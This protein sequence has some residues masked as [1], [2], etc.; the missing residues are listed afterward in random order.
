MMKKPVFDPETREGAIVKPPVLTRCCKRS[1]RLLL[2][3]ARLRKGILRLA[4]AERAAEGL[5]ERR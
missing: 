2:R 5:S 3:E 4:L 1:A